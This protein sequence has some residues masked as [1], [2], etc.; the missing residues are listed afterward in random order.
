MSAC[1]T[2]RF[3]TRQTAQDTAWEREAR[4]QL[5]GRPRTPLT[6]YDCE[7][8]GGAHLE[9]SRTAQVAA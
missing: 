5:A 3:P 8:C 6:A 9:R 2:E 4:A 7:R 1:P